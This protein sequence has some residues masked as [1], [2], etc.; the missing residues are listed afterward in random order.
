M[1]LDAQL[2]A[3]WKAQAAAPH[4]PVVGAIALCEDAQKTKEHDRAVYQGQEWAKIEQAC[5]VAWAAT[6]KPAYAA[7]A[8][9]FMTALL[10]DL[11][12]IGDGKGGDAAALRDSGYALRNLGA[13][14]ALAYD[15]LYDQLSPQQ[16]EHARARWAAWLAGYA[17]KGYRAHAPGSN[18]H[19][20]YVLASTTIA[21]A[22]AGEAGAEGDAQWRRV[23]DVVWGEELRGALADGGVLAGG[24]WF[25]GWQY[26][27]LSVAE[28][29]LGARLMRAAGAPIDGVA[30]WLDSVLRRHVYA[31]SPN[32]QV[33]ANGDTESE[34]PNIPPRVLTLDAIALGDA[35]PDDKRWAKGE[36]SRLKLADRDY[37]LYDALAGVG[38][39]PVVLP[40]DTWPT[41]YVAT[42]TQTLYARTRWDARAV[43]FVAE[44]A[45]EFDMDHRHNDAGNFVL[46]RGSDD[47]IVDPSPYGS[48]SSLTGN[49]PTVRSAQLPADQVPSQGSYGGATWTWAEQTA[50]GVIAA[51]CD[52]AAR[53]KYHET[54]SDVPLALRDFVFLPSADGTAATLVVVDRAKTGGAGRDLY[55]RFRTPGKLAASGGGGG[56]GAASATVGGTRLAIATIARSTPGDVT[57]D[58]PTMKDCEHDT[59][60]GACEAA[61]FPI[62]EYRE[63][64]AGPD[65]R[66]VHAI[67]VTDA[68]SSAVAVPGEAMAGPGWAGV[69]VTGTRD[70]VV[71]WPTD[72]SGDAKSLA[73]TAPRGAKVT[74][75]VLD[76]PEIDDRAT[77]TA[78]RG[79]AG[80]DVTVVGGGSSAMR[81]TPLVMTLDDACAVAVDRAAASA[82][83][84]AKTTAPRASGRAPRAGCCD[85][86]G[87]SGGSS[88]LLALGVVMIARRRR[89]TSR[90]RARCAP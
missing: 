47:A 36:L 84:A 11:D 46:S 50:S 8:T 28:I 7:T 68:A 42:A 38:D 6:D 71:V 3:A 66:A 19:A 82:P 67:G 32:D 4:G 41:W 52:Y 53:F 25:E 58:S 40:R 62:T 49:A 81:A 29:A 15:W 31:L 13:P 18:Y 12:D 27:P 54:P 22:E 77:V 26:A 61:R 80:C 59:T 30:Q 56:G 24:D 73:Y 55:L 70:A 17:A 63:Q 39:G 75:V 51:R 86:G 90:A 43:W 9:R 78:T 37:L 45:P 20:G 64:V 33:F 83:S 88:A 48:F 89:A 87:G 16:R 1:L 79:A 44:C 65:A 21:I 76:A 85:A 10:D 72:R 69:R 34:T 5:L 2:R 23:V 14:T 57:I 74:H 60:R 35:S